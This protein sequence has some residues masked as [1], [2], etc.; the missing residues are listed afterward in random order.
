MIPPTMETDELVFKACIKAAGRIAPED[1]RMAIIRNTGNLERI[2][3]SKPLQKN[4]NQ[5]EDPW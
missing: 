3:V 5:S 2:W 1:L 4:S